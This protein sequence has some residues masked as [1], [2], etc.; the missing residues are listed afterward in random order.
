MNQHDRKLLPLF[1][2]TCSEQNF[3]SEC[4]KRK[5]LDLDCFV[6]GWSLRSFLIEQPVTSVGPEFV[7]LKMEKAISAMIKH[8]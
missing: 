1:N 8:H 4:G 2:A 3:F 5:T 7:F 6:E